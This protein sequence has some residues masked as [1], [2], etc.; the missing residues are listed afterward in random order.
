MSVVAPLWLAVAAA[1]AI[2]VVVAHL[3]STNVPPRDVLPTVRFV[4]AGAPM[5]VLRTRRITDVL[6]LLLRL[7][8]VGLLG[9]ALAG[10]HVPRRGPVRVA[11]VDLSRAVASADAV[12][13]RLPP[14]GAGETEWIVVDSM[15]RSVDREVL[16]TI[17][18]REVPG[19]LSAGVAAALRAIADRS[20]ERDEIELVI[21]SPIVREEVDSATAGLVALWEGPVRFIRVPVAEAPSGG[22]VEVPAS[23]DDPVAAALAGAAGVGGARVR[24]VRDALTAADSAWARQTA[25]VLV[26]WPASASPAVGSL[27]GRTATDTIGAVSAAGYTVV[28]SFVRATRPRDG[29]VIARW[30]DG[31]PAATERPFGEGCIRDIAIPVDP[32]GDM[33]LRDSFRALART[34]IEPCG[35]ARE[36]DAVPDSVLLRER[37]ASPD[38]AGFVATPDSRLPLWLGVA[39]LAF[40]VAEQLLR[41]RGRSTQP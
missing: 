1:V 6:L 33:A 37:H 17:A 3:F 22:A 4:P 2:G 36:F 10:A 12:R 26:L 32:I 28:G 16:D 40:L 41:R 23:G 5:A 18:R 24:I 14:D 7:L 34:F 29:R 39:A 27:E 9:L 19:A 30:M 8:A 25:H 21:V 31:E 35:G 20:V 38:V 11:V 15:A 13:Q